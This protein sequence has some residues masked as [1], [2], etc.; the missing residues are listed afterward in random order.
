MGCHLEGPGQ[1]GEVGLG[2]PHEAQQG[3]VQG[4]TSG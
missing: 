4:P 2:E 1:A 3:Q